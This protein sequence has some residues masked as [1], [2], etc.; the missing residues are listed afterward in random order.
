[1]K[2][3]I[4]LDTYFLVNAVMNY[5][6][7]ALS[8]KLLFGAIKKRRLLIA[9][10]TGAVYACL[11]LA[12]S[13]KGVISILLWLL[14]LWWMGRVSFPK[15]SLKKQATVLAMNVV[16]AF[17]T[18]GMLE[19]LS[20]LFLTDNAK[21]TLSLVAGGAIFGFAFF[22]IW[23][24]KAREK[25]TQ[26]RVNLHLT[27]FG[28]EYELCG[29]CDSANLLRAPTC[30]YPVILLGDCL[31]DD[32]HLGPYY[33]GE[34]RSGDNFHAIPMTTASGAKLIYGFSP[35]CVK[36]I[37]PQKTI[38]LHEVM[39]GADPACH[40]FSDCECLVPASIL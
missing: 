13:L 10:L 1:M 28:K 38:T 16:F 26:S 29:L 27:A 34:S 3:E 36:I 32:E 17:L 12:F 35:E 19:G 23:S 37:T 39:I 11:T 40:S 14:C 5:T 31:C 9:S 30:G 18:G 33:I 8:G 20:S 22:H 6:V 24:L 25:L 2:Q 21:F 7:L 15:I 4:Y